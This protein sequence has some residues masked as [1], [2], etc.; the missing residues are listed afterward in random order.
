M[1]NSIQS[2]G[3]RDVP[4]PLLE[5]YILARDA[6]ASRSSTIRISLAKS[7][8]FPSTTYSESMDHRDQPLASR[9]E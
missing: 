9:V 6:K 2:H 1:I 8:M 5:M 4:G 7:S 3:E